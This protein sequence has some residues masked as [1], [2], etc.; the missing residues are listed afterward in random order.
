M[1]NWN[2]T[3]FLSCRTFSSSPY[4]T[5]GQYGCLHLDNGIWDLVALCRA[6]LWCV[7]EPVIWV[8]TQ[9]S[10][11]S[12]LLPRKDNFNGIYNVGRRQLR[13][14]PSYLHPHPHHQHWCFPFSRLQDQ[15]MTDHVPLCISIQGQFYCTSSVFGVIVMVK[16]EETASELFQMVIYDGSKSD[17]SFLRS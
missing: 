1:N 16:S 7:W 9:N 5:D 17:D 15:S 2:R 14:P 8:V 3:R 11:F 6:L 10:G 4:F 13:S 12:F